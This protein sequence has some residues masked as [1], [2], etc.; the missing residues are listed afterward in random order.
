M[1]V[2][3]IAVI[4]PESSTPPHVRGTDGSTIRGWS[5]EENLLGIA[6]RSDR[7]I[8]APWHGLEPF[9]LLH[10]G[11]SHAN[12]GV[13]FVAANS[14]FVLVQGC[15]ESADR[16]EAVQRSFRKAMWWLAIRSELSRTLL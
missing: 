6:T 9:I 16:C 12:G 13:S 2:E 1:G 15:E 14:R 5:D 11:P 8:P 7:A 4:G 10:A 3:E